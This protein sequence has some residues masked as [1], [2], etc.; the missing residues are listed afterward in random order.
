LLPKI[1][2]GEGK[3]SIALKYMRKQFAAL[4][5][6]RERAMMVVPGRP[7]NFQTG[8]ALSKSLFAPFLVFGTLL[9][10][11]GAWHPACRWQDLKSLSSSRHRRGDVEKNRPK[12]FFISREKFTGR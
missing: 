3:L 2:H 9:A 12:K 6:P 7:E 1:E 4:A 5:E 8:F 10:G 11:P